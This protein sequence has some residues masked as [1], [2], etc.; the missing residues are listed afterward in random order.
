MKPKTR[1][2]L[3]TG[4][5]LGCFGPVLGWLFCIFGFFQMGQSIAQTPPGSLADLG[6]FPSRVMANFIPLIIGVVIGAVGGFLT[7]YALITH[8]FRSTDDAN[9]NPN[10]FDGHDK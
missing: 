2:I 7:L 8:F 6:Q 4:I 3:I 9:H 5:V 10:P 1:N